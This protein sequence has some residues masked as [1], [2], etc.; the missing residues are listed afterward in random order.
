MALSCGDE[1]EDFKGVGVLCACCCDAEVVAQGK[2][3]LA[4]FEAELSINVDAEARVVLLDH[5]A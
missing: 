4:G 3:D 2:S 1:L 5:D